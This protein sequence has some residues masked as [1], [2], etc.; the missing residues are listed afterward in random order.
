MLACMESVTRLNLN[1]NSIER[2]WERLGPQPQLRELD[3]SYCNLTQVPAV[4]ADM[5]SV[6]SLRLCSNP[7]ERGWEHLRP[8]ARLQKLIT[9]VDEDNVPEARKALVSRNVTIELTCVNE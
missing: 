1:G 8:L 6:T 9:A 3:L 7:I 5:E 4:L 2:G